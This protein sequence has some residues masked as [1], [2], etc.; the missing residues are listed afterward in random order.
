VF[1][2]ERHQAG[3]RLPIPTNLSPNF[4]IPESVR[5]SL[6]KPVANAATFSRVERAIGKTS[7][8]SAAKAKQAG[9]TVRDGNGCPGPTAVWPRLD[10]EG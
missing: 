1:A 7:R 2:T 3:A 8:R 10:A 4:L 6:S 5:M 9:S